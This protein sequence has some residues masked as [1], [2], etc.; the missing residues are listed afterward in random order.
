MKNLFYLLLLT[1]F[2]QANAQTG[3]PVPEMTQADNLVKNFMTTYAIPG[4]TIAL[5]KD[6]KIV[7]MRGF[8]YSDIAKTIPVQPNNLFRIASCSK[9]ITAIAIMKL[10]QDGKLSMFS[11][12]FGPG[13]ILEHAPIISTAT[14]TDARIYDITVEHLLEHTE[15]WDRDVN[16]NSSPTLPYPYFFGGCDPINNPLTVSMELGISNPVS[17][18][19]L[20]KYLLQ[21]GLNFAPGTKYAYSNIGYLCLGAIIEQLTGKTYED[22]V[23][24]DI[25]APL[26]IY[27]TH[28]G[29]N[30]LS[31]KQEREVE[32]TTTEGTNLSVYGTGVQAPWTYGGMNVHAM[33]AHGGWITTASDFVKLLSAVDGFATKPD[34]LSTATI[35]VMTAPSTANV[36]YAKGWAVNSFGNWWH[37]GAIPGTASQIVRAS[38]GYNW[39]IIMN[40]RYN[41]NNFWTA[42]DNLGWNIISATTSWPTWDLMLAPTQNA[43]N[44][45]LSNAT[46]TSVTVNWANGNGAKRLLLIKPDVA[47]TSFP[48]DGTDYTANANYTS[49][50]ILGSDVKIV[51]NGTGNSVNVTGLE[52]GKNYHFRVIE[53]NNSPATGNNSLYLLG[54]N[55]VSMHTA[56]ALP[57]KLISFH[58]MHSNN[59]IKLKWTTAQE[60]NAAYYIIQRSYDGTKF[61][62]IGKVIANGNT[63]LPSSYY[64]TD[65]SNNNNQS[66]LFYKI[67][68]TDKDGSFDY[69]PIISVGIKTSRYFTISPNPAK[70]ILKIKGN[71]IVAVEVL[72]LVG[73]RLIQK[74]F[75][76]I[77]EATINISPLSAGGYLIRIRDKNSNTQTERLIIQK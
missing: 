60:I 56:G 69:S 33:S 17:E 74:T 22:Y 18:N 70:D 35:N 30:L 32:Y 38:N 49:A 42:L 55:P 66:N 43:S 47:I 62:D 36:N 76:D 9:Q 27:D 23:K 64:F 13:G 72:D 7:Y 10:M 61:S 11:K 41:S 20:S 53:Y 44:I 40:N 25:L 50:P 34:I 1:S 77:N 58:G 31:E 57:V 14:I 6:G 15:G 26:G 71:H 39:F 54:N 51:Y 24:N 8:G 5:T 28:I 52:A 73:R 67:K 37:T 63:S 2:L 46:A 29:N 48:L 45:T 12:V 16:C 59:E 21:K 4:L 75:T 19:Y 68:M 3:I 65:Q